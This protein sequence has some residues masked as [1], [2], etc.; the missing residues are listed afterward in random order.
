MSEQQLPDPTDET[1]RGLQESD[2]DVEGSMGV[3]SERVGET[4][5]GDVGATGTV[6]RSEKPSPQ[7]Q[8]APP[9]QSRG[10]PETNPEGLPP[11]AGYSSRDPRSDDEV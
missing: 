11:K 7:G 6:D 9:E 8:D 4:G 1:V 2:E 5:A 10:N 3:S